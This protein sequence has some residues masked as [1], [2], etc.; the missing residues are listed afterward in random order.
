LHNADGEVALDD[1]PKFDHYAMPDGVRAD[2]ALRELRAVLAGR[3]MTPNEIALARV[4]LKVPW[5][6]LRPGTWPRTSI[7]AEQK[8]I[9][10]NFEGDAG[11]ERAERDATLR[12]FAEE[13]IKE[14]VVGGTLQLY[15]TL[16]ADRATA[17]DRV[18]LDWNLSLVTGQFASRLP[19]ASSLEG[20]TLW[21]A[22]NE[23][24]RFKP[25]PAST[26]HSVD[27]L[28]RAWAD[29]AVNRHVRIGAARKDA[30][31]KLG[32]MAPPQDACRTTLRD[33]R[34]RAGIETRSGRPMG[35]KSHWNK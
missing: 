3:A 1:D 15:V 20:R 10:R 28:H 16:V 21:F 35:A 8:A 11:V 7:A 22:R 30:V 25:A 2:N 29:D 14:A 4:C 33:A 6:D 31:E 34:R 24:D 26:R 13:A 9:I 19:H 18:D 32:D 5:E 27:E 12:W 23:W 17:L